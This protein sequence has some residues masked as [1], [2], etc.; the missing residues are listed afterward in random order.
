MEN[1]SPVALSWSGGKDSAM[2]LGA[3]RE[4]GQDVRCLLTT[5]TEGF[6]RISMHGV[7][8]DLVQRQADAAG[9]PLVEVRIPKECPNEVYEARMGEAV[10]SLAADGVH[11]FAFGDLFLED[12]REY[13]VSRLAKEGLQAVFPLWGEDTTQL[14]RSFID[15]GFRAILVTVDPRQLAA[16]FV[17]RDY[18]PTLLRDLPSSVDPCGERG[19]FHSF[20]WEGPVFSR[21]IPV[22]R[23]AAVLRDG[24]WFQDLVAAPARSADPEG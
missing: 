17:G 24:F 4:R 19:E 14:A 9:L 15:R 18:D 12:V 22:Q 2:A 3:L 10:R 16:D 7:R 1:L 5:V 8:R 21:P 6:E 13:R 20:V 23:G 11:R